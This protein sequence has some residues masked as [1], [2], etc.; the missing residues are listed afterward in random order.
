M[1]NAAAIQGDYVDLRF[2]KGRKVCQVVI[3]LPI[4]AG[5]SFV[6]AFGTPNPSNGVPVALARIDPNA[7][8]ERKG[9]KLAQKAGILCS[10]GAFRRYLAEIGEYDGIRMLDLDMAADELR[11]ICGVESRADLDHNEEAA[12][13]FKDLEASYKAW[14]QVAA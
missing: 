8:P 7:K 10:E 11:N 5:A 13:K 4:E 2:V 1:T 12:R 3:E 6:A 9:G 14:M